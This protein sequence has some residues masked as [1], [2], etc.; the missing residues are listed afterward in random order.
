MDV[1][2]G[3]LRGNGGGRTTAEKLS[4]PFLGEIPL[5]PRIVEGGDAGT[6]I[7]ELEPES[8]AAQAF[9]TAAR[10]VA[11]AVGA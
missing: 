5:Y 3:E 10:A 6:P 4:L 2:S 7:V 1:G 9:V 8:A 11:A